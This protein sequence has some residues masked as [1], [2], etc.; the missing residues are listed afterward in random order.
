M[1]EEI[2]SDIWSNWQYNSKNIA[3]RQSIFQNE[4]PYCYS[5]SFF[6]FVWFKCNFILLMTSQICFNF[7]ITLN[8]PKSSWNWDY[9]KSLPQLQILHLCYLSNRVVKIWYSVR[10]LLFSVKILRK[11]QIFLAYAAENTVISPNFLVWKL[12][13]SVKFLHQEIRWNYGIFRSEMQLYTDWI[14]QFF[15]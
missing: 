7:V 12:R 1:I 2:W 3:L 10:L 14:S 11:F 5:A 8:F 9:C 6:F 4:N 15:L 13:L